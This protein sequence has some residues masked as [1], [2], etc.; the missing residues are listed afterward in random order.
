MNQGD[1]MNLSAKEISKLLSII[2]P[3]VKIKTGRWSEVMLE[4]QKEYL[5]KSGGGN[6]PLCGTNIFWEVRNKSI[7]CC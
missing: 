5:T 4:L 2:T 7:H 1:R 3:G 6:C